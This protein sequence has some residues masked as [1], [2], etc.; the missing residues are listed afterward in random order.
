MAGVKK[1]LDGH[2]PHCMSRLCNTKLLKPCPH[3]R[4]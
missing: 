4:L 3:W 1:R 2:R